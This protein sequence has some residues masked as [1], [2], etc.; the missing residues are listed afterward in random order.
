[1]GMIK[2][3][4]IVI[5]QTAFGENDKLLTV[6]T[7]D[8]GTINVSAKGAV[9]K[10]N[11]LKA[12]TSVFC[13]SDFVLYDKK[14]SYYTISEAVPI[15]AFMGLSKDVE[16]LEAAAAMLKFIKYTAVENIECSDELRLLLNSLY[17]LSETDKNITL[18][19]CI[20]YLKSL[21]YMGL[22]P[23]TG[24]CA[25]CGTKEKLRHFLPESGGVICEN[26]AENEKR[27]VSLSENAERLMHYII[28]AP[29]EKLFGINA[30][31]ALFEEVL[32][33]TAFFVSEHLGYRI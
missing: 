5:S 21:A 8:R 19:K 26:C 31:N 29:S 6:F 23:V 3:K 14:Y 4:G 27:S 24:E 1:M 7:E 32:S 22:P 13:Y 30:G 17:M 18:V 2:T 11:N 20:F 9:S 15:E 10:H 25:V 28:Y 12:A 33:H 16:R